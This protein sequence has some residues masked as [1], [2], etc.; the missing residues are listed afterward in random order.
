VVIAVTVVRMM[1]V[2]TD[3][4]VGVVAVRDCLVSA[5]RAVLMTLLGASTSVIW[6]APVRVRLAHRD[7]MFDYGRSFLMME[8]PVVKVV[9]M[10]IVA[11]LRMA[12]IRSMLVGVVRMRLE[13]H[14]SSRHE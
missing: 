1:Q 8:V 6:C 5:T 9:L 2:A 12:A 4:V 11:N 14:M 7:H 3:E 13:L 10:P